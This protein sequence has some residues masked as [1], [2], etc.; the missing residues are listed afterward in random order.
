MLKHMA[1]NRSV[2]IRSTGRIPMI[3]IDDSSSDDDDDDDDFPAMTLPST[4]KSEN[5]NSQKLHQESQPVP[6]TSFD[7]L[8]QEIASN[9]EIAPTSVADKQPCPICGNLIKTSLLPSHASV[10]GDWGCSGPYAD[11]MYDEEKNN[12]S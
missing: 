9:E 6:S 5:A 1:G 8:P 2:Y 10:C 3:R 12:A 7:T 4:S 11:I